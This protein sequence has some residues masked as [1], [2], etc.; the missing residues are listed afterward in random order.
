MIGT[1]ARYWRTLRSMAATSHNCGTD[2]HDYPGCC[3]LQNLMSSARQNFM[4]DG[5]GIK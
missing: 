5:A 1:G 3:V 4:H 2:S